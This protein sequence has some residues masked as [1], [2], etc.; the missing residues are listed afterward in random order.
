MTG[1][2]K[3]FW[4]PHSI[5]TQ[6]IQWFE[7][8][9]LNDVPVVGG[10]NASLGEMIGHLK[11]KGIQVPDGFATTADAYWDFLRHNQLT[12][13]IQTLLEDYHNKKRSL[14]ETGQAIR[15]LFLDAEMPASFVQAIG[16]AYRELGKRYSVDNVD[17]A[18]R[19]SATAE[20]LP[21]AS[22]AGQHESYLNIRGQDSLI[23]ACK[24]CFASLFTDRAIVYREENGFDHLKIALSI[25]IQ[26]MIR[27]DK[28]S[29]GVIFTLETETGFPHV[30]V[31]NGSWGLGEYI[32]KG[33]V[34]PDQYLVFKPLLETSH[35]TP[36]LEKKRGSKER[37]LVYT[38]QQGRS[39]QDMSTSPEERN[40][41]VLNNIE[42]LQLAR[43]ACVI[44]DHYQCPMDIE[45]AKDGETGELFIV[46]A[47]PET[48][49]TRQTDG[50]FHT[51]HLTKKGNVLATGLSIG[52]QIAAGKVQRITSLAE[53]S[54]FEA[55]SI[56][57]TEMTEPDWVPLMKQSAGIV[58]DFG[59]RT[60]HAAI[61]SREFG[62]PAVVGTQN[63]TQVLVPGKEVTLSCAEGDTGYVYEGILPYDTKTLTIDKSLKTPVQLMLNVADPATSFKWWQL[64]CEGIGLARMEFIINNIIKIH[65][66]ALL[67]FET[68][69]APIKTQIAKLTEGYDTKADYFV[70]RLSEGIAKIAAS[71][72]PHSVIVRMSDFKTNEYASL[73]G[74]ESF[75]PKEP[76]PM[77]G[78]RG[79]SRY[80]SEQYREGFSL[81]CRA[82][83][84][85]REEMG[86][87]N[88]IVM[89]PFCRTVAEADQVLAEM[90]KNDLKRGENGLEV[91][92]MA[93]IPSN[94]ILAEE[95]AKRFDGF[96][97]GSNDLTQLT[98]GIDRDSSLLAPL[99]DEQ[100]EA[101]KRMITSLITTAHQAGRKVGIC[102]QAPSDYP[103][104]ADFLVEAG[105]DSMSLNADSIIPVQQRLGR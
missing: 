46:Q 43:W 102:G 79:A 72:Y 22:F 88:I 17:V 80:Y 36:I 8:L 77:I 76:N 103:A 86:L 61:V 19:S 75:E 27:S 23:E 15:Q 65:P 91:Y 70:D 49:Q 67:H 14:P 30:V 85:V 5:K 4:M 21:H 97:I 99:F 6:F 96:S 28:A 84:R 62:I 90:A 73:I 12:N 98:L 101:V 60:C 39:T 1:Y 33:T 104:F 55:G 29:A 57:V 105:I 54:K 82:I 64:P 53:A 16:E 32:V 34:T 95:F 69:D 51:Y 38:D 63:A 26:K 56:L 20:D 37:K 81:E 83:K 40:S 94:I 2:T 52:S 31:V 50:Q 10:K 3:D 78:F 74:G 100:N 93:E 44:E 87:T 11:P 18:V 41:F 7:T 58:T 9:T 66:L 13:Q 45:W 89:I 35:V 48:V 92:M 25:G 59:G 47:R 71:Q 24:E 42:L 68:L